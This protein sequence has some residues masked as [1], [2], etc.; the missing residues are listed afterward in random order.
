MKVIKDRWDIIGP[1][2]RGKTVLDIGCVGANKKDTPI[3]LHGKIKAVAKELTGLE[4]DAT[5]IDELNAKGYNIIYGDC[6]TVDLKRKFQVI[7][8][9]EVIE[10]LSNPGLFF[11]NMKRHLSPDGLLIITTPNRFD[12]IQVMSCILR[13]YIP[14][15]SKPYALHVHYYDENTL[16]YLFERYGYEELK[17]YNCAGYYDGWYPRFTSTILHTIR[18]KFSHRLIKVLRCVNGA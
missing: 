7:V 13:N 12:G 2:V 18:P 17:T 10:H 4:I 3:W 1:L 9:S 11:A 5:Y 6:E 8:A 16:R 14:E 15:Y